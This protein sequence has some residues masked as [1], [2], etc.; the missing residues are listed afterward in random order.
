MEQAKVQAGEALVLPPALALKKLR[1]ENSV[2]QAVLANFCKVSQVTIM[3]WEKGTS[4]ISEEGAAKLAEFFNV[5]QYTFYSNVNRLED[6]TFKMLLEHMKVYDESSGGLMADTTVLNKIPI[7]R[8]TFG[9][10]VDTDAMTSATKSIPRGSIALVTPI[11]TMRDYV[12]RVV[13]GTFDGKYYIIKELCHDGANYFL[14]P[15]NEQYPVDKDLND[16]K[17]KGVVVG[18]FK[19]V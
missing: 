14:R 16:F 9:V 5:P 3:R 18:Y 17:V 6:E 7:S 13:Y 12:R 19:P 8:D 2:S 15:W 4:S 11:K 10:S 1:S